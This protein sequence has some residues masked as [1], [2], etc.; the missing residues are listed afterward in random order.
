MT[1]KEIEDM[2]INIDGNDSNVEELESD[3]DDLFLHFTQS[4]SRINASSSESDSDSDE[5]IP[6]STYFPQPGPG[7]IF[8]GVVIKSLIPFHLHTSTI[9]RVGKFFL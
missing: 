1:A 7:G 9:T 4:E 3:G 2:L 6:L 5:E 8:Y